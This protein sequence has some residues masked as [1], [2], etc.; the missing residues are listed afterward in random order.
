MENI[1]IFVLI[2]AAGTVCGIVFGYAGYSRGVRKESAQEGRDNGKLEANTDY[3]RRRVDDV[4]FEQRELNKTVN[5]HAERLTRVEES[6]KQAHKRLD[7]H[8]VHEKG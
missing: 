5:V 8:I 7:E 3:I 1:T 6:S 2:G 4:L